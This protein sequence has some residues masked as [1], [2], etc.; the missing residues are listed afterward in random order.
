MSNIHA[1][2]D[3][4]LETV[5]PDEYAPDPEVPNLVDLFS[6]NVVSLEAAVEEGHV[7]VVELRDP[8]T[9][10]IV[11]AFGAIVNEQIGTIRSEFQQLFRDNQEILKQLMV[12]N[13]RANIPLSDVPKASASAP[14]PASAPASVQASVPSAVPEQLQR[15]QQSLK[16]S[17]AKQNFESVQNQSIGILQENT[18]LLKAMGDA[19]EIANEQQAD[20]PENVLEN[21]GIAR[22]VEKQLGSMV[23]QMNETRGQMRVLFAEINQVRREVEQGN[24]QQQQ[25]GQQIQQ[26]VEQANQGIGRVE[27][28]VADV[29][30]N[31]T[32]M[33]GEVRVRFD[34][35]EAQVTEFR[36][37]AAQRFNDVIGEIHRIG[38]Y[39]SPC[40]LKYNE[41]YGK[42]YN[43]LAWC[44]F[45]FFRFLTTILA[46]IRE[47]Y[48]E[49]KRR[50]LSLLPE[51]LA[52][53]PVRWLFEMAIAIMEWGAVLLVL[54]KY[55][56]P[57]LGIPNLAS[58]FIIKSGVF[59]IELFTY[60]F[61]I[62]CIVWN[63]LTSTL[64][65]SIVELGNQIGLWN[66][67][68][69][70]WLSVYAFFTKTLANAMAEA[71][72]QVAEVATDAVTIAY[73][74]TVGQLPSVPDVGL[75]SALGWKT[76]GKGKKS[77]L[78][79]GGD[80]PPH[81]IRWMETAQQNNYLD[82]INISSLLNEAVFYNVINYI[83]NLEL[84][85]SDPTFI[86]F[87]ST[88]PQ[89]ILAFQKNANHLYYVLKDNGIFEMTPRIRESSRVEILSAGRKKTHRGF[90]KYKKNLSRKVRTTKT[91]KNRRQKKKFNK[92]RSKKFIK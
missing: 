70:L 6:E 43:S 86:S 30:Q 32:G 65:S 48:F 40:E 92:R 5:Q 8:K 14:A 33:R 35:A 55:I 51:N 71:K 88:H 76:G 7:P 15:L 67:L 62:I 23:E 84:G 20:V 54:D 24:V 87:L 31:V 19:F 52:G 83:T 21:L 82:I 66:W 4:L 90:Y 16:A 27:V 78:Y 29:A 91:K 59:I 2:L 12:Q 75:Y 68:E 37:F 72:K 79:G 44:I 39:N 38:T 77:N 18:K 34:Q 9:R 45:V 80:I 42:F 69:T 10:Q 58:K 60:V 61:N 89:N 50:F 36:N 22:K 73:D 57:L 11:E 56:G 53:V 81:L 46:V 26:G 3:E 63:T 64:K 41:G 74:N 49:F 17:P 25:Q 85:L 47:V 28:A 13:Q 1:I